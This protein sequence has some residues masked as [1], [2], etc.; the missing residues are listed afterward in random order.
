MDFQSVNTY[1]EGLYAPGSRVNKETF[2]RATGMQDFIPVVDDDVARFLKM[3]I[4]TSR[5]RRILEIGTSIGFSTCS[6]AAILQE[7][8]GTI[9]TLEYDRRM[10]HQA[11]Q[12]FDRLGVGEVIDLQV[13]DALEI[14]PTLTPFY[15]MVF[16]DVDK[17]LYPRLLPDCLRLLAPGGL[18]IAEDTLFPV[19]DLH[20]KW[21]GL[22]APIRQFNEMV[23]NCPELDSTLLPIGDGVI[24]AIKRG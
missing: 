24:F 10:A 23:V 15:D 11:Q 12:N 14:I 18:L 6:M 4:R 3:I 2:I 16:Q 1:I 7:Y 13:G 21:H 17:N 9:T 22:I 20:P 5:P 8:G 19:L